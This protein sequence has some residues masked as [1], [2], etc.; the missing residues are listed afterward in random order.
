MGRNQTVCEEKPRSQKRDLGHPL[1][2]WRVR[3]LDSAA[4][5]STALGERRV[6]TASIQR[7]PKLQLVQIL[8]GQQLLKLWRRAQHGKVLIFIEAFPILEPFI[9]GLT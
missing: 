6:F 5:V 8:R 1:E 2:V 7:R 3:R 9:H 4:L